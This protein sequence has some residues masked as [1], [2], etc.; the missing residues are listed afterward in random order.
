MSRDFM[1]I[2]ELMTQLGRERREV[3]RMV[4]RGRIPGRR[5]SG[6]WRFNRLEITQWLE[7][8]IREFDDEG[9]ARVEQTQ[10][11]RDLD[12]K[13]P[14]SQL[15]SL[16]TVE[17]PLDAGTKPSVLQSLVEVAGRTW[18]V[19]EP[20]AV[21]EAVKQREAVMSTGFDNGLAIPHPRNPL[22]EALGDSVVAFGRTTCGIPFGGPKR[23]L[24]DLF[25]LVLA[26]DSTTHLQILARIGRLMQL[27]DFVPSL[28][29]AETSIDA[30][31]LICA[32]DAE[33]DA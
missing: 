12:P 26:R 25:F 13:S 16:E 23:S 14:L 6:E 17:V 4:S 32:A 33:I 24:T 9:L 31:E 28:R 29:T 21:L 20:A 27:P 3:E 19:L 7:T 15:V 18:Q 22:P 2:D 1:T 8:E 5:V 11:S 30:Y 10:Q